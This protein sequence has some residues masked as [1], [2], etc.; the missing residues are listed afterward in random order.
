MANSFVHV[1]L[2][3][4][5]ITRAKDFY[6]KLF[7]WE[8]E[9]I[10]GLD[11]TLIKVGEGTGG[12]MMRQPMPDGPSMWLPYVGVADVAV[13]TAEAKKLGATII[14]DSVEVANVG[15]FSVIIDPTGATIALWQMSCPG[16]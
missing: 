8:L 4:T 15:W 3:T 7:E 16:P 14:K 10:S 2:L 1:E 9:D 13:A 6:S 11:Y 5:N 12:G